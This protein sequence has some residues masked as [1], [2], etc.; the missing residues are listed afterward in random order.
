MKAVNIA[1]TP[2]WATLTAQR[3]ALA[4]TAA[5]AEAASDSTPTPIDKDRDTWIKDDYDTLVLSSLTSL[6]ERSA[7]SLVTR[8]LCDIGS[9]AGI[10]KVLLI[11]PAVV[12]AGLCETA[13]RFAR[14]QINSTVALFISCY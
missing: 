13:S 10:I 14:R 7:A 12:N 2:A 4:A 3:A 1:R 8:R 6:D 5:A 9:L 11:N